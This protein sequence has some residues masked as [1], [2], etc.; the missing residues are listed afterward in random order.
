MHNK[1]Y[2]IFDPTLLTWNWDTDHIKVKTSSTENVV[3]FMVTKLGK[4]S[5]KTRKLL[6]LVASLGT[7]FQEN[8]ITLLIDH[9]AGDIFGTEEEQQNMVLSPEKFLERCEREGL[10][11][12]LDDR[13]F[14]WE[15]DKIQVREKE[16]S[17]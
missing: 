5:M 12:R 17:C 10:I 3:D 8:T 9:L 16:L 13:C 4:L 2:N 14:Q 11:F 6:P 15:H 7:V 1:H